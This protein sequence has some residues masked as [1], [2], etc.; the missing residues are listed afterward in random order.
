MDFAGSESTLVAPVQPAGNQATYIW[1]AAER[2]VTPN[3]RIDYQWRATDGGRTTL[4]A[5][6]DAAL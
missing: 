5:R 3:T 1:D 2:Y 6:G 4:S